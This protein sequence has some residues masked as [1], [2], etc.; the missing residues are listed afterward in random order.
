MTRA[1][2]VETDVFDEAIL[3]WKRRIACLVFL[4]AQ[5]ACVNVLYRL[6]RVILAD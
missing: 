5:S 4:N 2:A 3:H 1:T 6:R